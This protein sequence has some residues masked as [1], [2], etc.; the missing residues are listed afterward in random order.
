MVLRLKCTVARPVVW[1]KRSPITHL[2]SLIQCGFDQ[3]L[4][5]EIHCSPCHCD[6]TL[7]N[8]SVGCRAGAGVGE[9][10]LVVDRGMTVQAEHGVNG[11]HDVRDVAHVGRC[12]HHFVR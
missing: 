1:T 12:T 6:S 3:M 7:G 9:F 2:A 10:R 8:S 5:R 4:L 11:G